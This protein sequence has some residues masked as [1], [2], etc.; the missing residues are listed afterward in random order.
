MYT[1]LAPHEVWSAY[2]NGKIFKGGGNSSEPKMVR[3]NRLR[4]ADFDIETDAKTGVAWVLPNPRKG[5]SFSDSV[6]RLEQLKINGHIWEF[7]APEELP[8][9]LVINYKDKN[10][11]LINVSRKM[12]EAMAIKLLVELGRK[13]RKTSY[14]IKDG[15]LIE[16]EA[17]TST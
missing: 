9:G 16:Q 14:R 4:A 12:T 5:L 15:N 8:D 10:H 2:T 13:M 6:Q 11:P 1:T 3:Q 17:S 7:P